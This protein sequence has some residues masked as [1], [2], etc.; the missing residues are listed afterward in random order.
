M[1]CTVCHAEMEPIPFAGFVCAEHPTDRGHECLGV[2]E[3]H[4]LPDFTVHVHPHAFSLEIATVA[5]ER[6]V[7]VAREARVVAADVTAHM[8]ARARWN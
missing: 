5:L 8:V 2:I 1:T 4:V 7:R 3:V 6:A